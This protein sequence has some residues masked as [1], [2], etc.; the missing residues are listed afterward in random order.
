MGSLHNHAGG[1]EVVLA[2]EMAYRLIEQ[3]K[4]EWLAQSPHYGHT[5]LLAYREQACRDVVLMQ[6]IELGQQIF[7]LLLA[8]EIGQTVFKH[9]VLAHAY[10]R[11]KAQL[12]RQ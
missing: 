7:Y 8:E 6:Q 4:V 3:Q 11:K 9:Y 2:V 5:L 12:L 1:Y 10:F